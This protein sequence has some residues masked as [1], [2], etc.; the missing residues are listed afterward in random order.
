MEY[1]LALQTAQQALDSEFAEANNNP[2]DYCNAM[3]WSKNSKGTKQALNKQGR[4]AATDEDVE[5]LAQIIHS[6]DSESTIEVL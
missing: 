4:L 1:Q 2:V 3:G 6:I 5:N